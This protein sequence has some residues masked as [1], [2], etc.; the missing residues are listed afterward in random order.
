[1][2]TVDWSWKSKSEYSVLRIDC[3]LKRSFDDMYINQPVQDRPGQS[4]QKNTGDGKGPVIEQL[5]ALR[6]ILCAENP[7]LDYIQN[8]NKVLYL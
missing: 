5:A 1:M 3:Y 4:A 6:S 2:E 7:P 8:M